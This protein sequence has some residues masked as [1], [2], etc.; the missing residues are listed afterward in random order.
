MGLL[1]SLNRQQR[2]A[3]IKQ[4]QADNAKQP[5]TMTAVDLASWPK[6]L[7]PGLEFA[8]RSRTFLAQLYREPNGLRRSVN[9]ST[10]MGDRWDDNISWDELMRVKAECGFGG[11]WAVEVFPPEQHV[12]NVANMRHLWLLDAAPDFAWKRVA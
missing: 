9:R 4:L 2:R 10:T 5:V 8:W 6:K 12:V 11:Y 7:P 3:A 1:T